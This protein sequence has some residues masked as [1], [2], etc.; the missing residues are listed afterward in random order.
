[1]RCDEFCSGRHHA[2][3][4]GA[5]RAADDGG[6]RLDLRVPCEKLDRPFA[7]ARVRGVD[8]LAIQREPSTVD[9]APADDL[10]LGALTD[11]S[12]RIGVAL[13]KKRVVSYAVDEEARRAAAKP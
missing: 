8:E 10:E 4:F 11:H 5:E 7:H 6:C 3:L 13:K 12:L 9:G 2:D 1:M